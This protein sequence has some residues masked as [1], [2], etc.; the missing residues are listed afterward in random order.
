[1]TSHRTRTRRS[2]RTWQVAALALTG[3][4]AALAFSPLSKYLSSGK[5]APPQPASGGDTEVRRPVL[6]ATALAS[7]AT[8]MDRIAGKVEVAPPPPVEAEGTDMAGAEPDVPPEPERAPIIEWVYKSYLGSPQLKAATVNVGD[9]QMLVCVGRTYEG[10][11]VLEVHPSH[12]MIEENGQQRRLDIAA[13]VVNGFGDGTV[14]VRPITAATRPM[15]P[16]INAMQPNNARGMAA[17]HAAPNSGLDQQRR[18]AMQVQAPP[19][20]QPLSVDQ[21]A[22]TAD[23]LKVRFENLPDEQ[24]EEFK[25]IFTDTST[26]PAKR[27]A[28]LEQ[29]GVHPKATTEDRLQ[30]LQMFGVTPETDPGLME[31]LK[32]SGGG[33]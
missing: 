23:D 28:Q 9:R 13:R 20:P 30:M 32:R 27:L 16:G 1:M 29:L 7:L 25:R 22:F 4:A 18:A 8:E 5:F 11:K 15:P 24:R 31:V 14:G 2:T 17:G 33:K 21:M 26:D 19:P 6:S 10:I 12:M 3:G